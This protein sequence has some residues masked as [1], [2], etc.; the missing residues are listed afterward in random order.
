MVANLGSASKS[1]EGYGLLNG[2][3][4]LTNIGLDLPK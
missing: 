1:L 2:M 4:K 3:F